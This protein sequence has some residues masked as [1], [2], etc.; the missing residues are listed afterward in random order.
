MTKERL[1]SRYKAKYPSLA[2]HDD[3]RLFSALLKKYPEYQ[4]Q[5]DN[6]YITQSTDMLNKLP[7]VFKSAY[8]QSITGLAEE[9]STGKK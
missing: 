8:N 3:D 4:E 5:L 1:V 2:E 9:M 6:P 7:D